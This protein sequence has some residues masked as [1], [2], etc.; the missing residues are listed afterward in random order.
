MQVLCAL[1]HRYSFL[2]VAQLYHLA[3]YFVG[4]EIAAD[5]NVDQ[6]EILH[7][8]LASDH[9]QVCPMLWC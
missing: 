7:N 3:I 5:F 2:C 9:V 1:S 6:R 8:L 4:L